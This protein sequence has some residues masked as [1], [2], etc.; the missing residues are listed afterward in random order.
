MKNKEGSKVIMMDVPM[1]V[2][3]FFDLANV[4]MVVL[5]DG[6]RVAMINPKGCEVLGYKMSEILGKNWFDEFLPLSERKKV[7]TYWSK[8]LSGKDTFM[9]R[10]ESSVVTKGGDRR[11]ISWDNTFLTDSS[12]KIR[13]TLSSGEDVTELHKPPHFAMIAC[14]PDG[15]IL[16][17]NCIAL[18]LLGY[19]QKQLLG[20]PI[21]QF[22]APNSAKKL[23]PALKKIMKTGFEG[24]ELDFVKADNQVLPVRASGSRFKICG[25]KVIFS[26]SPIA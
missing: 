1:D 7:Q 13:Y 23:K 4:M 2:R 3:T 12:G 17:A 22:C 24:F 8:I 14:D 5:D 6:Q 21:F 11:L 20:L 10:L 25:A 9:N 19:G 26:F 18:D 16:D 15:K